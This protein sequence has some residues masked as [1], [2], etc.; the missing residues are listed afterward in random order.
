MVLVGKGSKDQL[1]FDQLKVEEESRIAEPAKV[2]E[3]TTATTEDTK[4]G[5]PVRRRRRRLQNKPV[6]FEP[7]DKKKFEQPDEPEDTKPQDG[8]VHWEPEDKK[9]FA[10]P[11]APEHKE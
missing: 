11:D 10:Q 4:K 5:G 8:T 7:E 2:A 3:G 9:K 1:V 6:H